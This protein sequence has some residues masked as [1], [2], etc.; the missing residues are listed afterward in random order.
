IPALAKLGDRQAIPPLLEC[1][2][3][4]NKALRIA[5]LRALSPLTDAAHAEQVWK[6]VMAVRESTDDAD[7]KEAVNATANALVGKRGLVEPS[8]KMTIGPFQPVLHDLHDPGSLN[9]L[10]SESNDD[11][12]EVIITDAPDTD[13]YVNADSLEPG[14]MLVNRYRVIRHIGKG[15]FAAV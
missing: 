11:E 14:D 9:I 7:L 10:S 15:G 8:S 4:T 5:A 3:G 6:A 13:R 12:M 2:Q 1:L